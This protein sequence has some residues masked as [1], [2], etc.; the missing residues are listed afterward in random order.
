MTAARRPGR[1]VLRP[2]ERGALR[3]TAIV[4]D[5]EAGAMGFWRAVGYQHQPQQARFVRHIDLAL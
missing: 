2:S 4:A 5:D 1:V 3:L